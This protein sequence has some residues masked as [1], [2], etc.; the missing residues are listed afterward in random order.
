MA[1]Y[2][3]DNN[4]NNYSG[5]EQKQYGFGGNDIFEAGVD[6]KSYSL[7][8]G[9]G[10]DDLEGLSFADD[11]H[12]GRG[13]DELFGYLGDDHLFGGKG[14][15]DLWG[16]SGHDTLTGGRGRD[17]FIYS[18]DGRDDANSDMITDFKHG[19][20]HFNFVF[21]QFSEA[22]Q[23]GELAREKFFVGKSAHDADDRFI[24]NHHNGSLYFDP[25]GLDGQHQILIAV[26]ENK[27]HLNHHDIFLI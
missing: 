22:G 18:S 5:P 21:S 27:A 16:E 13:S 26:L 24:Y 20:D 9:S 1:T 23:V 6:D 19:T 10:A 2:L 15:D 3:G 17:S 7:Y 25:D 4:D 11:L 8:G 14:G 12:G